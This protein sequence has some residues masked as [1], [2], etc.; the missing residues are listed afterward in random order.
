[1]EAGAAVGVS[2]AAGAGA[3]GDLEGS[4]DKGLLE[5]RPAEPGLPLMQRTPSPPP[6]GR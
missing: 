6:R 5:P 2:E 1:M 4:L 3:V